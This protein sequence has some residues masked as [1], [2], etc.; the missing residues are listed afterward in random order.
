[1]RWMW[2]VPQRIQK[3]D[4]EILQ[5][6]QRSLGDTAVIRQIR[7]AAKAEAINLSIA[8][9]H[10]DWLKACPEQLDRSLK[11]FE[12]DLSQSTELV[13]CVENVAER[14]ADEIS[15]FR[16][17]IQRE[18]VGFVPKAERAQII[19]AQDVIGVTVS[20]EDGVQFANVLADGL[21]T[22]VRRSIDEHSH[23]TI[24]HQ[25]GGSGTAVV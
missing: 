3:Q 17:R 23:A 2:R 4:V 10:R 11:R 5:F 9:D 15:R 13:V 8:V 18:L 14:A 6:R 22:E 16:P 21:L 25:H 1:M 19:Q 12:F 20:V 7:S 24:L